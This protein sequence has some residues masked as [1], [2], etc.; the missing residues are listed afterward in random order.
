MFIFYI[1]NIYKG[2]NLQLLTNGSEGVYSG[3]KRASI[4]LI[5]H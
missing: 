3:D 4:K 5:I 2:I 1:F